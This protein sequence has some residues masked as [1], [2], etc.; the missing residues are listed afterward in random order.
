MWQAS[1]SGLEKVKCMHWGN[2]HLQ[3]KHFFLCRVNIYCRAVSYP[4]AVH[5][6]MRSAAVTQLTWWRCSAHADLN[7]LSQRSHTVLAGGL[8]VFLCTARL[9]LLDN[10]LPHAGHVKQGAARGPLHFLLCTFRL[11]LLAKLFLHK[12]Q[13]KLAAATGPVHTRWCISNAYGLL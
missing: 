6:C 3:A 11:Y 7:V 1:I 8:H 4:Q 2:E 10:A 5:V 9:C 13:A 12:Q